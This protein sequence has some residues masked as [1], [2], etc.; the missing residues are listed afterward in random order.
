MT[1]EFLGQESN[2]SNITMVT[3]CGVGCA[4]PSI[5]TLPKVWARRRVTDSGAWTLRHRF[6]SLRLNILL[7]LSLTYCGYFQVPLRTTRTH[8]LSVVLPL[9]VLAQ[10]ACLLG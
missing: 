5:Y 3:S 2:S 10:L 4:F 6:S 1:G 9:P 7:H 8:V